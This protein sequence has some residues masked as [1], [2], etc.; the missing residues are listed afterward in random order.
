MQQTFASTCEIRRRLVASVDKQ[1]GDALVFDNDKNRMYA[2]EC[3]LDKANEQ[4]FKCARRKRSYLNHL[5]AFEDA[6]SVFSFDK[7]GKN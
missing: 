6:L 2:V 4:A 3:K 7:Y 5:C 1:F